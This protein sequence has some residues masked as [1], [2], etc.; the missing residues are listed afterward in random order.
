[1]KKFF[2]V[3]FLFC[4]YNIFAQTSLNSIEDQYYDFLS[5]QGAL[6]RPYLGYRSIIT[7]NWDIQNLEK[8]VWS[9]KFNRKEY[10]IYEDNNN[11]NFF[12]KGID[13]SIK[14]QIL[15]L[16]FYNSINTAS[17]YGFNDESLW[18]G[19]GYN[20]SLPSRVYPS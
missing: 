19:K 8:S 7:S 11:S 2:F 6:E 20:T 10:I 13:S 18:Q 12:H 15:D 3:I 9:E 16:D 14:L 5:L 4:L 1:M 17:P